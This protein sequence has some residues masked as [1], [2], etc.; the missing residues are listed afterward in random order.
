M[1]LW[2]RGPAAVGQAARL[3][4]RPGGPCHSPRTAA[5]GR[6]AGKGAAETSQIVVARVVLM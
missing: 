5:G 3:T 4:P 1:R 6:G 2:R